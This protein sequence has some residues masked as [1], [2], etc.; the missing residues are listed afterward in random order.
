MQIRSDEST[1]A[2]ATPDARFGRLDVLADCLDDLDQFVERVALLAG[3]LD[4]V[5]CLLDDCALF[6]SAG[7]GDAAPSAELEQAFVAEGTESA[8]YGVRV[9]ADDGGEVSGW[10]ESFAWFGFTVCDGATDGCGGL[11]EQRHVAVMIELAKSNHASYIST[12]VVGASERK[13]HQ[14]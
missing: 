10:W 11:F 14:C 13:G 5:S 8:E 3:E 12:I 6:G 4:E 7:D 2:H 1:L 9:D